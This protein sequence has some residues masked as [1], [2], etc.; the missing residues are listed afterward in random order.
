M[1]SLP[2]VPSISRPNPVW[3]GYEGRI[4]LRQEVARFPDPE[5]AR[6]MRGRLQYPERLSLASAAGPESPFVVQASTVIPGAL[7]TGIRFDLPGQITAQVT[8]NV[9]DTPSGRILLVPQGARLIGAYDSEVATAR[10]A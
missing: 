8:E 2:A 5:M 3:T 10:R 4:D 6:L 9:L 7:I 1:E